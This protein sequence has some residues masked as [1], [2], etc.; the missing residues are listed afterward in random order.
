[1]QKAFVLALSMFGGAATCLAQVTGNIA[2]S[3]SGGKRQ[4]QMAERSKRVVGP[5]D[6]PPTATTMFIDA[7][8]LMNVKADEHVATFAITQECAALPEC[9]Q[10][11]DATV[12][13]FAADLQR[14]GIAAGDVFVDFA[15]QNKIYSVQVP[16]RS[17]GRR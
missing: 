9:T 16:A 11:I 13:S 10:R 12:A 6:A 7:A 17:R 5:A 1:M 14:L 8:V 2:Y 15:A 3:Q 4:A